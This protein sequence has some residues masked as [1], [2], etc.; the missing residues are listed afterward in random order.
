[1]STVLKLKRSTT[2]A[3]PTL[4]FGELAYT[5]I[6]GAS[7]LFIGD[8]N[9]AARLIAGSTYAKI[10]SQ[11]FTGIPAAPTPSTSDNSTTLAT[12]AFVKNAITAIGSTL[13]FISTIDCSTSPNYPAATIGNLFVVSVAGKIGGA[14]GISVEAGDQL[15]CTNT[16][17][18][19]THIDVG[20]NWNITQF[21]IANSV[22]SSS[23]TSILNNIATF[24]S[25]NGR[26]VKDSGFII[27]STSAL[28]QNNALTV[29]SSNVVYNSIQSV[30]YTAG[31]N[32]S[33]NSN[34]ISLGPTVD[35]GT[36]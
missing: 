7:N 18:A 22:T 30:T 2:T 3:S 34:A 27:D 32:I 21:N 13:V 24:D 31:N 29:P 17:I 4:L 14:S 19:G 36:F 28:V 15:L 1:M 11:T 5:N 33:I 9:N 10:D 23:S 26:I 20:A 12:T 25:T 6:S 16:T 8:S 35:L